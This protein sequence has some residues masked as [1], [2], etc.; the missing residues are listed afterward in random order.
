MKLYFSHPS[1]YARKAR[2]VMYEAGL[3]GDIEQVPIVPWEDPE[4]YRDN[5]PFGKVPTLVLDDRSSLFQSNTICEY[6]DH[7]NTRPK[8]FPEYWDDRLAAL[9]L[10]SFADNMLDC[11]IVQ[12]MEQLFHKDTRA[13]GL[14]ERQ[15][16][17]IRG[18]LDVLNSEAG[19]WAGRCD[20]GLISVACALGYRDFRFADHDW[21]DGHAALTDWYAGFMER[22]SMAATP[23]DPTA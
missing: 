8:L 23:F 15:N 9:R 4:G 5:N 10:L 7:L 18:A 22:S 17:S 2:A 6:L 3:D 14:Y 21:R 20:I 11:C 12:R 13:E 16:I 19:A 1:P